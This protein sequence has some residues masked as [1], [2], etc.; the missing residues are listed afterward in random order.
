MANKFN[1]QAKL[2]L[3][4][5]EFRKGV[6]GVQASL[7]GLKSSFRS[8]A[9]GLGATLGLERL[10]S[11]LK[12]T[13]TKLNVAKTTLEN[14]S[15]V[16]KKF[17]TS[18]GEVDVNINNYKQN[19]AFVKRLSSEYGQDMVALIDNFAKFTASSRGTNLS[20]EQQKYIFESLTR[21]AAAYHLS[22][23]RTTDMLNA[24]NQMMSK[25]K[26]AAEELRR[27]LGNTL[28]GAFNIMAA[29]VGVST[30]ELDKMMKNG[31]II[32]EDV[33]P[34]FAETL[35]KITA[36]AH[37]DSLQTSINHLKNEWYE[38]VELTGAEN[39]FKG[40]ID[41]S[42]SALDSVGKNFHS[43]AYAITAM[44]VSLFAGPKIIKG[45]M[46]GVSYF[47]DYRIRTE[48]EITKLQKRMDV[49]GKS[50]K[51]QGFQPQGMVGYSQTKVQSVS[52]ET[53][54]D[55]LEYNNLLKERMRLERSIKGNFGKIG[56][57]KIIDNRSKSLKEE[58]KLINKQNRALL[59]QGNTWKKVWAY[60]NIGAK[61]F[62]GWIAK[63]AKSFSAMLGPIGWAMI[64]IEA[65][66]AAAGIWAGHLKKVREEQERIAGI[67]GNLGKRFDERMAPTNEH[68]KK[69]KQLKELFDDFQGKGDKAGAKFY[70]EKLQGEV[71]SLRDLNYDDLIKKADGLEKLN[72][73]LENYTHNIQTVNA[74]ES[75]KTELDDLRGR[76]ETLLDR[77]NKI[78][79]SG[80]PL[81]KKGGG[82]RSTG[83]LNM[84]DIPTKL[85]KEYNGIVRELKEIDGAIEKTEKDLA[86]LNLKDEGDIFGKNNPDLEETPIEKV[87][88][89]DKEALKKLKNQYKE[90]AISQEDYLNKLN[91]L[92]RNSY[93]DAAA[94]GALSLE[95]IIEKINSGKTLSAIE[96]WYY[97]L[98]QRAS[99]AIATEGLDKITEELEGQFDEVT[100]QLD[101]EMK[102]WHKVQDGEFNAKSVSNRSKKFD[103]KKTGYDIAA[104]QFDIYSE[105]VANAE[106]AIENL[107]KDIK[108][109]F[110][111]AGDATAN[112]MVRNMTDDLEELENKAKTWEEIMA[113]EEMKQDLKD[114]LYEIKNINWELGDAAMSMTFGFVSSIDSVVSAFQRLNDIADDFDAN[115]WEKFMASWGV[116]ESIMNGVVSTMNTINTIMQL[117]NSLADIEAQKRALNNSMLAQENA[118]KSANAAVTSA[119]AG[120]STAAAAATTSET[121]AAA[122]NIAAK[123]GEAIAEA[124]AA[125]AKTGFPALL[126][127]IPAGVAAVIAALAAVS[128]FESGGIVGG[129]S[130]KGDRNL[131]RVNSGEM[132]LN[133]AQQGTLWNMLNGKG[134]MGGNVNFKI[135]GADLIG[136]INNE[137][138]RRRG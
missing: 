85:G 33:L 83:D 36:N 121:A 19:L 95:K 51:K 56:T 17:S 73:A 80:E 10:V 13:A 77:K 59:V 99:T 130:T 72:T 96:R 132:I 105:K 9:A 1:F 86:D 127:A 122:G 101:K 20:L 55:M 103:Y 138:S 82:S 71:P 120:A 128:K 90:G 98:Y 63:A 48:A 67:Q 40:L 84:Y 41:T 38:F 16:T 3:D 53:L 131:V 8:F 4:S 68:I 32:A 89:A 6:R 12:D 24:V 22:A 78:E 129:N 44:I 100:E 137:N 26:V 49:I 110:G 108:L 69:V 37:F 30:A 87:Y 28:P 46:E 11:S 136:V 14:A 93:E 62:V 125:G 111:E 76:Q 124:T 45:V 116:F 2:G 92:A 29:A 134:G 70:F 113:L 88:K 18:M 21:A 47:K 58:I 117:S 91:Q 126:F 118:L 65:I 115:G 106:E 104:E 34:R 114:V 50:L 31:E 60:M 97:E 42:T 112:R 102:F 107:K 57:S 74:A 75:L 5:K 54:E 135:R 66:A 109:T 52:K 94:T 39:A 64:A 35:N 81:T 119:A 15:K 133:K 79:T 61:G 43:W 25:G 27:Q 7:N 123:S 23:D